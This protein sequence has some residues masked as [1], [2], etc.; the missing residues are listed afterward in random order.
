MN[1]ILTGDQPGAPVGREEAWA[2]KAA[3]ATGIVG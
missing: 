3:T 2:R 1:F